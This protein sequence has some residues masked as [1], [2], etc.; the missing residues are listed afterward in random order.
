M[1][2]SQIKT[3]LN[4]VKTDYEVLIKGWVR[5]KRDSR[6]FCF[7]EI[8]DGSTISN[9]QV[10]ADS[11]LINYSD[12]I[13]KLSTGCSL[14]VLGTLVESPGKGQENEIKAREIKV[15]G[16]TNSEE[17]PLQKKRHSFEF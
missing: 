8:N 1:K 17:Y 15:Y 16:W 10:I 6:D 13:I 11:T 2:R 5:T 7:I 12:E 9:I 3:I 4:S 14:S